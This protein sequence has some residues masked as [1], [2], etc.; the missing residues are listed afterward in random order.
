MPASPMPSRCPAARR[1]SSAAPDRHD[2]P[3]Q[4]LCPDLG[5]G[6]PVP[7]R[8]LHQAQGRAR[9]RDAG[10][11]RPRDHAPDHRPQHRAA[12]AGR[13]QHLRPRLS[14]GDEPVG[15]EPAGWPLRDGPA[16]GTPRGRAAGGGRRAPLP[17]P[18]ALQGTGRRHH[19]RPCRPVLLASGVRPHHHRLGAAAAGAG[20]DGAAGLLCAKPVGRLRPRPRHLRRERGQDQRQHGAPWL[21]VRLRRLRPRRGQLPPRLDL[22]QGRRQCQQPAALGD[23]RDLHGRRDAPGAGAEPGAGQ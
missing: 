4:P 15:A 19:A 10:P 6:R 2:R 14:A 16:P 18:V 23:D 20:R 21:R 22:P 3:R 1:P 8:R 13:A 9:C 5:P 11:L 17:R 12:P 7:P